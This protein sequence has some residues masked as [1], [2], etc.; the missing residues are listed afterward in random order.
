MA[1]VSSVLGENRARMPR[2]AA[3]TT[4]PLPWRRSTM[5]SAARS[6]SAWR[7][8][9]RLTPRMRASSSSRGS[10]VPRE[11][12]ISPIMRMRPSRAWDESDGAL[13]MPDIGAT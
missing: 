8:V 11:R 4:V 13:P 9:V 12:S 7:T 10:L 3:L 2:D 6:L 1:S 5:P